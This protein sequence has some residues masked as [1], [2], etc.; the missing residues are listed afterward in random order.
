ML[1][2]LWGRR[3]AEGKKADGRGFHEK[4]EGGAESSW[5]NLPV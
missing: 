1:C 4:E 3:D 5:E 2:R